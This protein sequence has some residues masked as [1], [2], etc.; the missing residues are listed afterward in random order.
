MSDTDTWVDVPETQQKDNWV[1]VP[2]T[3]GA[4]PETKVSEPPVQQATTYVPEKNLS[5]DHPADMSHDQVN[6]AIQTQIF[7]R[8]RNLSF[9]FDPM[10]IALGAGEE[11]GVK[12][13]KI[14]DETAKAAVR[15]AESVPKGISALMGVMGDAGV[16][17]I[18]DKY[19]FE[20]KVSQG[21]AD[22]GN[23]AYEFYKDRGKKGWEAPDPEVFRGSFM[24]NPSV[25]RL[26]SDIIQNVPLVAATA[27]ASA[28]TGGAAPLALFGAM[29]A[30]ES[31]KAAEA[32]GE[33]PQQALAVG[34]A[35]GI[36][37]AVL[38]SLPL[39]KYIGKMGVKPP[40]A[41]A[42]TFA[43]LGSL[44]TPFNNIM[45]KLGGDQTRKLFD[46]F[47]ES[48]LS[49]AASGF[50]LGSFEKGGAAEHDKDVSA[51]FKAGV[52]PHE[53]DAARAAIA[54]QIVDN[55]DVVKA[56][57]LE[58]MQEI[59]FEF[60]A[61]KKE[62]PVKEQ[63]DKE[64]AQQ[65][66]IE[67]AQQTVARFEGN[68]DFINEVGK[69]RKPAGDLLKEE[70]SN[71]SKA[72]FTTD[73]NA[74]G[75]DEVADRMGLTTNELLDRLKDVSKE[76]RQSQNKNYKDAQKFITESEQNAMDEANEKLRLEKEAN[77]EFV[78]NT[79]FSLKLGSN[80]KT[81]AKFVREEA[82]GIRDA[83]RARGYQFGEELSRILPDEVDRR[84]LFWYRA[85]DGDV[86]WLKEAAGS[87][88]MAQYKD[89][90]ERASNPSEALMNANEKLEKFYNEW[91]EVGQEVGILPEDL[92]A[93]YQAGWYKPEKPT[94]FVKT[95]GSGS[96]KRLSSEH[97]QQKIYDNPFQA[98]QSGKELA[99]DDA[100]E[101]MK[102]YNLDMSTIA[103]NRKLA[104]KMTDSGLA[105]WVRPKKV[106][107]GW[108][109]VGTISREIPLK[110]TETG[111]IIKDQTGNQAYS[112]S[113]LVA[114]K[115]LA[116]GLEASTDPNFLNQVGFFKNVQKYQQL[117]KMADVSLG[118]FHDFNEMKSSFYSRGISD[119]SQLKNLDAHFESPNFKEQE[120]HL[121]E[122][123]GTTIASHPNTDI[124]QSLR[125][126]FPESGENKLV[127]KVEA[128][129]V[130][131]SEAIE[132]IPGGKKA[133]ELATKTAELPEKHA[134]FLFNKAMRYLKVKDY[135]A[136]VADWVSKNPEATNDQ[137]KAAARGFAEHVN[138]KYGGLN[139]EAL[140]FSKTHVALLRLGEFAPDWTQAKFE[141]VK[142]S[143]G[144]GT[145]GSSSRKY[146]GV[147]V[148]AGML[149]TEG[150]NHILT[151]H[152]TQDNSKG[153]FMEVEISPGVHISL[154][155]G[156]VEDIANLT[157]RIVSGGLEGALAWAQGKVSPAGRLVAMG[158]SRTLYSGAPVVAR[159]H[160]GNPFSMTYDWFKALATE[161]APVPFAVSS[162]ARYLGSEE[163][164]SLLG[165]AI[166]GS[167]VGRFSEQHKSKK[168]SFA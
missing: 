106:P 82:S 72:F 48:L 91:G 43:A 71:I 150:L 5:I 141:L 7:D 69:F 165:T 79:P 13:P 168:E 105:A 142:Q 57:L 33:T 32:N 76:S 147:S 81:T 38:M 1:D 109:Q 42:A 138:A 12:E 96:F 162:I 93:A 6:D 9:K 124:I 118:F 30:G 160:R 87:E 153:H 155:P 40:V 23:N 130:K 95:E 37:N 148:A 35:S 3:Q 26:V 111:E 86:E 4:V 65:R 34:T 60:G 8:P 149:M 53:I 137:A 89:A 140:G 88:D 113:I 163:Q 114:P 83:Q 2:E 19:G 92:R 64:A 127:D 122:N 70:L 94:D 117:V 125:D 123:G 166:V 78:K 55:P 119:I 10:S 28:T 45:A 116:K 146:I 74:E 44:V 132:K 49:M 18:K 104:D 73:K 120:L 102:K 101:A 100:V 158:M 68:R 85:A 25:T 29:A 144:S 31:G 80:D 110:N 15:M 90:I 159:S 63:S 152:F 115:G 27:V 134:N 108:E 51:A 129:L 16:E 39:G 103:T 133:V 17:G 126:A 98:V 107:D 47:T 24:S 84:A 135:A 112:S 151:G 46:G 58:K 56:S 36:G 167:G 136:Q 41:N 75:I 52:T 128:G 154:L 20:S 145:A 21:F 50:I 14:L 143:L 11:A 61:N 66:E 121:I 156:V 157:A 164:K 99:T 22:I 139:W 62:A 54:K 131:A 97:G 59:K 161:L 67:E 77:R